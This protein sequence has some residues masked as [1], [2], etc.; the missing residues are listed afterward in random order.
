MVLVMLGLGAVVFVVSLLWRERTNVGVSAS[1]PATS[2]DRAAG[3]CVRVRAIPPT[4]YHQGERGSQ[5][6]TEAHVHLEQRGT[7]SGTRPG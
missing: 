5:Q 1:K 2:G 4:R 6:D 3:P 7:R